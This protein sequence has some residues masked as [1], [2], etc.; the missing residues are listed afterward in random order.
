MIIT[1]AES[2]EMK[3]VEELIP[4][5]TGKIII[6]GVGMANVVKELK[7]V[8][9]TEEILNIGYAGSNKIPK[10]TVVR[11]SN[12]RTAHKI[13][14]FVDWCSVSTEMPDWLYELE[15]LEKA[16]CY[17]STDFVTEWD[18]EEP[19]VFDMELAAIANMGFS[20]VMSIKKISDTLNYE[21]FKEASK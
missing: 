7:D 1:I 6:T 3:L 8:P 15:K 21:E 9:K 20:K 5:Y 12:V 10:G 11:I 19:A 2:Q 18:G 17:T 4:N 16:G 13:A 14:Q